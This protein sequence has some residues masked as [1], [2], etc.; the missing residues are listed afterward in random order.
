MNNVS[1]SLP[2]SNGRIEWLDVMKGVAILL[3]VMG[4][5]KGVSA[6][7]TGIYAFHMPLFFLLAGCSAAISLNRSQSIGI[8]CRKRL[9]SVFL[10]YTVWCFL[11]GLPFSQM[12]RWQNYSFDV[13]LHSFVCGDV[14]QWFLICLFGLQLTY[15]LFSRLASCRRHIVWRVCVMGGLFVALFLLHR[16][17]GRTCEDAPYWA[18]ES[19][20]NVYVYFIP[21]AIGV[22]MTEYPKFLNFVTGNKFILTVSTAVF[23]FAIMLYCKLPGN[24]PK[25]FTGCA[26]S[27]VLITLCRKLLLTPPRNAFITSI[28]R[29][30]KIIGASTMV[31]YLFHGTFLPSE[32]VSTHFGEGI[33]STLVMV[34]ISVIVSY[35]CLGIEK[36]IR[37]SPFLTLILLGSKK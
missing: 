34:F 21:F 17:V 3:V 31:I 37:L 20:T 29:Q 5:F 26:V 2:E 7:G 18:L 25:I 24:Y 9:I 16:A 28:I 27:I 8:F 35:I 14:A 30:L 19:V 10:P 33:P 11:G 6:V 36:C 1:P 4:H 32:P 22:A 23:I 12:S 13:H 15:A